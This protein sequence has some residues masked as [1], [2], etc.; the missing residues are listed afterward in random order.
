MKHI[1]EDGACASVGLANLN[2]SKEK[3]KVMATFSLVIHRLKHLEVYS[4]G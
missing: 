1:K 3:S 2:V 4:L